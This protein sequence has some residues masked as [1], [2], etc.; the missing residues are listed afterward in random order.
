MGSIVGCISLIVEVSH[1][2]PREIDFA[3]FSV[4][5]YTQNPFQI[6][7][8]RCCTWLHR[9]KEADLKQL[10]TAHRP[11]F[12]H[13]TNYKSTK[14]P[15]KLDQPGKTLIQVRQALQNLARSCKPPRSVSSSRFPSI[16]PVAKAATSIDSFA[17]DLSNLS[18]LTTGKPRG[19]SPSIWNVHDLPIVSRCF[20]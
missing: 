16:Y 5:P 19:H 13:H 1:G 9:G 8:S 14:R 2:I 17:W 10:N 20:Q 15:P 3:C 11:H 18:M 7:W 6:I 4:H 12:W